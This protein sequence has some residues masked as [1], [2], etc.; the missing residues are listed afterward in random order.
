VILKCDNKLQWAN[1][2]RI[3]PDEVYE[4]VDTEEELVSMV[5]KM[6]QSK[7]QIEN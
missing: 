7:R 4:V 5:N 3:Y 1:L 2:K 6:V